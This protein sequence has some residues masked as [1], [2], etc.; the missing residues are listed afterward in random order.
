MPTA[1]IK[2]SEPQFF[3]LA[4]FGAGEVWAAGYAPL[5]QY[6]QARGTVQRWDGAA[7]TDLPVPD[8]AAVWSLSGIAGVS[9]ADL[10]QLDGFTRRRVKAWRCTGTGRGGSAFRSPGP[11]AG[12]CS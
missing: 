2:G 1:V 11:R 12:R 5:R 4:Q 10:W 7:W 3:G 8:V 6:R 9:P